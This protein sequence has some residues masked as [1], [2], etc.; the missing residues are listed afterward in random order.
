[1]KKIIPAAV[2]LFTI[3]LVIASGIEWKSDLV[4][5]HKYHLTEAEAE[6]SACH[7]KAET[8]TKGTDDLLPEMET[9]YS[10]HDEDDTECSQCHKQPD[11]PILLPR[12]ENYSVKFNHK[13]HVEN[14]VACTVCH[15]GIASKDQVE[16]SMHLP[17]MELCMTCHETP[18]SV[19]GCYSCHQTT[20]NLKPVDHETGWDKNHGIVGEWGSV[21]CKSCPILSYCIACH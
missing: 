16:S 20:D 21:I 14:D 9:C 12:I 4:F 10:C 7:E 1:M 8:S 15:T 17:K 18:A 13:K 11:D 6:C 5:S 3:G 2:V 19:A